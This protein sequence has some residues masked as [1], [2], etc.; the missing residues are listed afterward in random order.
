MNYL[1]K[2]FHK[3][4][5]CFTQTNKKTELGFRDNKYFAVSSNVALCLLTH[6]DT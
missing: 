1:L 2:E 5:I 3:Q 4:N 6:N